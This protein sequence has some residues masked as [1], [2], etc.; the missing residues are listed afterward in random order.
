MMRSGSLRAAST[1]KTSLRRREFGK[2]C[3]DAKSQYVRC[4]YGLVLPV[5]E[6]QI[7]SPL[8]GT[9]YQTRQRKTSKVAAM[10]FAIHRPI[11]QTS[12]DESMKAFGTE[13]AALDWTR[14]Q[15]DSIWRAP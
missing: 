12:D 6:G 15:P 3:K 5:Q 13:A 1:R 9:C 11:R 8:A 4:R 2:E 10:K 14:L 7:P